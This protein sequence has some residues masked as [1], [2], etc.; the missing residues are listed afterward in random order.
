ME[1]GEPFSLENY[2]EALMAIYDII[3]VEE[4]QCAT[5]EGRAFNEGVFMVEEFSHEEMSI[6]STFLSTRAETEKET[7]TGSSDATALTS[8]RAP[9]PLVPPL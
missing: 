6:I 4:Q 2:H 3:V 9:T 8:V 1:K 5:D 7:M